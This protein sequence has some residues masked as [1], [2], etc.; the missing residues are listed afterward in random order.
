[1]KLTSFT[2]KAKD[3]E[4]VSKKCILSQN[5]I[6]CLAPSSSRMVKYLKSSAGDGGQNNLWS[7]QCVG[8]KLS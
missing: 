8:E 1:M 3:R 4:Q 2:L 7:E 6:F 5:L